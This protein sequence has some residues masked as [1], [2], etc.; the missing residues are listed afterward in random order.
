MAVFIQANRKRQLDDWKMLSQ[1]GYSAGVIGSMALQKDRPKYEQIFRF[2]SDS[3]K[4]EVELSK[5]QMIALA[6]QVNREYR[7]RE[8]RN[9]DR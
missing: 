9:N 8:K 3:D 2:P 7:K 4:S 6:E 5:A 1:V